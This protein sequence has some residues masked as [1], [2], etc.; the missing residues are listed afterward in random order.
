[1]DTRLGK[2]S[3]RQI[4]LLLGSLN[5]GE[6]SMATRL[7]CEAS[8]RLVRAG[9]ASIEEDEDELIEDI[10]T[11]EWRLRETKRKRRQLKSNRKGTE[12]PEPLPA[13]SRRIASASS[14]L[15]LVVKQS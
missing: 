2:F 11:Y 9:G 15:R 10:M 8:Y 13:R 14:R 5:F 1:M 12:V 4:A 6:I 7:I 3:D